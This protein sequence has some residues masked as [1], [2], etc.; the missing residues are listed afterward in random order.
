[1]F[2]F[3]AIQSVEKAVKSLNVLPEEYED[4]YIR[5]MITLLQDKLNNKK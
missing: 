1:M 5:R 3:K 2:Y 4:F